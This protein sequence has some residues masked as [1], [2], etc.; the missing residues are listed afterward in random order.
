MRRRGPSDAATHGSPVGTSLTR[1]D[2][3]TGREQRWHRTYTTIRPSS[4]ATASCP[5]RSKVS[6]AHPNGRRC[7]RCSPTSKAGP[8]SILAA[9]SGGSVDGH[10]A[11]ARPGSS[12]SMYPSGCWRA[13]GRRIPTAPSCTPERTWSSS[14]PTRRPS[15]SPIALSHSTISKTW[16]RCWPASTLLWCRAAS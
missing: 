16:R 1:T 4:R 8:C 9:D 7:V 11:T 13:R 12:A 5:V 15:T 10:G 2:P 6:T 3:A 14:R